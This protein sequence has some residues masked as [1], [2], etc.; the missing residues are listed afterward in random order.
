MSFAAP[1]FGR[2]L[3]G[4]RAPYLGNFLDSYLPIRQFDPAN[5]PSSRM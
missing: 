4:Y 5:G 2:S 3:A 1:V